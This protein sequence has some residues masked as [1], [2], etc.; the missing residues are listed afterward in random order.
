MLC[1]C[2]L[3]VGCKS[4]NNS[5]NDISN[6]KNDSTSTVGKMEETPLPTYMDSLEYFSKIEQI[7]NGDTTGTW[8]IKNQPL[9]LRGALLP[10]NRIVAYYGNLYSKKMGILGELPPKEMWKRLEQE[11]K[12]WQD[13]D[14]KTPVIPALHYIAVT[15]QGSPGAGGMYR[16][17][18]PH[19]QIDSVLSMARMR[20]GTLVFLDIQV[21]H[22]TL[23][24]EI[25]ELEKYLK[26][27]HV[28][29]GIDPEF[30]MKDGSVPGRKIGT[31]NADDIN[32]ATKYLS[33]LVKEYN[34]PP[35][36]LVVHRFTKNMVQRYKEIK[37]RPET[38]VVI[39]MDGWGSPELK[40]GTYRHFIYTEP[41][42]FTGFKLFYKNDIKNPPHQML[43]PEKLMTLKPQPI[44]IQYQ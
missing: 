23:Q 36:V 19:H 34:L 30:S 7:A 5:K 37:L 31:F 33:D 10:N 44:Y 24:K 18:M 12:R 14:P 15:A 2:F 25:P 13:A 43:T 28:H 26:M 4:N 35:K 29:L 22:S 6:N 41:I 39:D 9:P 40:F 17:R 38:Q 1:L 21:G 11:L 8:L 16:L 42:Q 20:E 27:P 32:Y 3:V